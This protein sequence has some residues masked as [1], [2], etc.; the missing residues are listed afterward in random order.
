M[1]EKFV[2]K[3]LKFAAVHRQPILEGLKEIT[4]RKY[5]EDKHQFYRGEHVLATFA[6]DSD[7]VEIIITDDTEKRLFLWIG[8]EVFQEDGFEGY[9]DALEGMREYYP[10]L[11][12]NTRMGIIRFTLPEN[13]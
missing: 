10:D 5:V 13:Y 7:P 1:K 8:D 6:D 4:L 3:E 2:M 11:T 9:A 12:P